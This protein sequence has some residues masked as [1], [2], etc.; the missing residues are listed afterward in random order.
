MIN[1]NPKEYLEK[2][3]ITKNK[4]VL[5][6]QKTIEEA[7]LKVI[8]LALQE[9]NF[10]IQE[11]SNSLAKIK[12][13]L[14]ETLPELIYKNA[15]KIIQ[16]ISD[17]FDSTLKSLDKGSQIAFIKLM[18]S[19]YSKDIAKSINIELNGNTL[20]TLAPTLLT[21]NIKKSRLKGYYVV[22]AM[23]DKKTLKEKNTINELDN[24]ISELEITRKENKII[25]TR[26]S[27]EIQKIIIEFLLQ[28]NIYYQYTGYKSLMATVYNL[29]DELKLELIKLIKIQINIS[30]PLREKINF[31]ERKISIISEASEEVYNNLNTINIKEYT[32]LSTWISIKVNNDWLKRL[33]KGLSN[34]GTSNMIL[35]DT[36][37]KINAAE[38]SIFFNGL[39]FSM[40]I[41]TSPILNILSTIKYIMLNKSLNSKNKEYQILDKQLYTKD[42]EKEYILMKTKLNN[43]TSLEAI[44]LDITLGYFSDVGIKVGRMPTSINELTL[45]IKNMPYVD[46]KMAFGILININ[47]IL[48]KESAKLKEELQKVGNISGALILSGFSALSIYNIV[49]S[50]DFLKELSDKIFNQDF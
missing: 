38:N 17:Q 22:D 36:G 50:K 24:I 13:N 48:L 28:N 33:T 32:L 14:K 21:K 12:K 23:K 34:I 7:K 40:G 27:L 10:K 15:I 2:L 41:A 49:K 45:L 30:Q 39:G 1:L 26:F 46:Q 20:L 35:F 18:N 47:K 43:E 37:K 5:K 3:H 11:D 25:D 8:V 29:E 6:M 44:I 9:K 19:K 4:L 16:S 31:S 42:D